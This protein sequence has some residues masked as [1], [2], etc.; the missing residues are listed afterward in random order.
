[1]T[2][3]PMT[4]RD[5]LRAAAAFGATAA[6]TEVVSAAQNAVAPAAQVA[7]PQPTLMK[8]KT[9]PRWFWEPQDLAMIR[10]LALARDA[11]VLDAGCGKGSH[12]QLFTERCREGRVAALDINP[13]AIDAVKARFAASDL[14][15]IVTTH[16][17]NVL[18]TPF[19]AGTFDLAWSSHTMHI[20]ADPVAGVRELARVVKPGGLVVIRE[21]VH[22]VQLL[23]LDIGIGEPGIESRIQAASTKWLAAD[24]LK[25]GRVPFGWPR[26]LKNAGLREIRATSFTFQLSPPLLPMQTEYL[27]K[28]LRRMA[29]LEHLDASDKATLLRITEP[30]APDDALARDDLHFTDIATVFVGEA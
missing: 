20:L 9:I 18:R 8:M 21:D 1:M 2:T 15:D 4:R 10:S 6:L 27:R 23:P 28:Y 17:A 22:S 11:S 3:T 26:V 16:E 30:G 13:R 19:E 5:A 25:R 14:K 7:P 24:R 29:D 12:V